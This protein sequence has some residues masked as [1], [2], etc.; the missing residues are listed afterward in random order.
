MKVPPELVKKSTLTLRQAEVL[1]SYVDVSRGLATLK[2]AASSKGEFRKKGDPSRLSV[3]SYY[4]TVGQ[5]RNNVKSSLVTIL[6]AIWQGL[7]KPE[8]AYR[9]L[10]L[11][12]RTPGEWSD[13]DLARFSA[14]LDSLL[15]KVIV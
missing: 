10:E 9:L 12:S 15:D 8:D 6:V 7:L 2:Q 4:R 3:G 1:E 14:L 11:G 13:V 5:A